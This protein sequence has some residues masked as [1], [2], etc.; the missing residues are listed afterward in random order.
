[1][2]QIEQDLKNAV[3][4]RCSWSMGNTKTFCNNGYVFVTVKDVPVYCQKKWYDADNGVTVK[5]DLY[6]EPVTRLE[7]SR[8]AVLGKNENS[9]VTT[10]E[11]MRLLFDSFSQRY[12]NKSM[13]CRQNFGFKVKIPNGK[14]R[15]F[16]SKKGAL[17]FAEPRGY[18]VTVI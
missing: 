7:K 1:M 9:T 5:R 12:S 13:R 8:L 6:V 18:E 3:E 2:T 15:Y 17:N 4:W 16:A 14:T 11:I 10:R